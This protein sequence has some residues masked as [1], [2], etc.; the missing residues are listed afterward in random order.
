MPGVGVVRDRL[1][2]AVARRHRLVAPVHH[3]GI[4]VAG[5]GV[6]GGL[7][8]RLGGLELAHGARP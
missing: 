6:E 1:D 2:L 3:P 8:G 4:R 5:A 7:H